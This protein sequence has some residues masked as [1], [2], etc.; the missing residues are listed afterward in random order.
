MKKIIDGLVRY[1]VSCVKAFELDAEH[2]LGPG[3]LEEHQGGW[4]HENYKYA[5]GPLLAVYVTEHP[6]NSLYRKK[7]VLD[8]YLQ[9]ADRWVKKWEDSLETAD[10]VGY[11][12]W[13]PLIVLRGLEYLGDE[14]DG[15]MRE[16]WTRMITYFAEHVVP[17]PFFFTAPNHEAWKLAVTAIA[18]RVLE[19]PDLL[20]A[21]EFKAGQLAAYQTPEGFWEEGRHHGPSIKYNGLML[22]A[23]TIV[24]KETGSA[25]LR[26]AAARLAAFMSRWTFPDGTLAGV[27]DGRQSTSPGY[28]GLVV[29]GLELAAEGVSH[30][31]SIIDFWDRVGWLDEPRMAGPS[32]WYAHFGM[33]FASEA[34]LHFAK[35]DGPAEGGSSM[36]LETDGTALENHTTLFG[37]VM[38]RQGPWALGI[39]SQLS[40]VPKDCQFIYRLERQSR[41]EV[42]HE[43]ASLVLGGGQSL[44][45]CVWPLYNVWAE[46]GYDDKPG[47]KAYAHTKGLAASPEYALRRSKYYA[48]WAES[49]TDGE[50]SWL[51]LTYASCTVRFELAPAGDEMVVGYTYR[52]L[53][54]NEL[55]LAMPVVLWRTARGLAGEKEIPADAAVAEPVLLETG[56]E[57]VVETPL[58]GTT[59]TLK[60]PAEG[61]GRVVWPL[62]PVRTYG[63]LFDEELFESF[64]RMAL[65]ETVIESPPRE[66]SGEWRLGVR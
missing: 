48:R 4:G 7:E 2:I 42:W 30:M 6:A 13:P 5:S 63:K 24:A 20:E 22:A 10:P 56:E 11:S 46:T 16:R 44:V 18:G 54:L 15:G 43:K 14:L 17:Q 60:L 64:F 28:F 37:A 26:E 53:G 38:R 32:N 27:L 47:E 58:L 49:G 62:E 29:P 59:A 35:A 9:L 51:E 12:E 52:Q 41:L 45:N 57:F 8:R 23:M 21:A 33:P 61:K 55:R 66:G 39:C 40:D 31:R 50:K 65:V 36:P 19:R 25:K 34:L 1:N 3:E